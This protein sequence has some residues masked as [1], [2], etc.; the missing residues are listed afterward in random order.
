MIKNNSMTETQLIFIIT[1]PRSG[2]SMLQHIIGNHSQVNITSEP[3]I[4]FPQITA[5]ETTGMITSYDHTISKLA[6]DE[7]IKLIENG[8]ELYYQNLRNYFLNFYSALNGSGK[9]YFLDKT[10]RYHQY[11]DEVIR[12]FPNA[13]Y[14]FLTRNPI[15]FFA[16]YFKVNAHGDW[17]KFGEMPFLTDV[18]FG[19][20]NLSRGLNNSSINSL[21]VQ[22]E[23]LVNQPTKEMS[24]ICDFLEVSLEKEM[25]N[26]GNR[27]LVNGPLID[28]KSIH[29]HQEPVT[30]YLNAWKNVFTENFH[31]RL[32]VEFIE[33]IGD[34]VLSNLGYDYSELLSLVGNYDCSHWNEMTLDLLL[35]QKDYR[36]YYESLVIRRFQNQCSNGSKSFMKDE[37]IEKLGELK[38]MTR[39]LLNITTK[40][41]LKIT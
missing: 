15:S 12:I 22:Y 41:L 6:L 4:L 20:K 13:K 31:R 10:T 23:N 24:R 1:L 27:N 18:K 8:E 34:K 14:I 7:K 16:S 19:Y 3:W 40:K 37:F 39:M 5:R 17:D 9:R 33:M 29:N 21:L 25:H 2:S 26:Y 11:L 28:P 36:N 38:L 32:V 30:D 35:K